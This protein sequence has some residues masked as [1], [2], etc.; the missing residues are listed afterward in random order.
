MSGRESDPKSTLPKPG[1][2]WGGGYA[3]KTDAFVERF[4]ESVSFDRRLAG[5]DIL[6]SQVHA[7]MLSRQKIIS[8]DDFHTIRSGLNEILEEIKRGEFEW[9]EELEDV[10]MNIEAELTSRIGEP[11]KRLHTG[12][13]RNDQVATDFRLYCAEAAAEIEQA[14][15]DLAKALNELAASDGAIVIPGYTHLQQGQPVTVATYLGAYRQMFERDARRFRGAQNSAMDECPLGS[16]AL[17]GSTLPLDRSFTAAKLGFERPS[18]N[19]M[20]AVSNRDFA[21]EFLLASSLLCVHLS[22]LAED[23]I[24]YATAEFG[25]IK[26]DDRVT[27]GSSLMPQKKNP[28][29][30]ELVR[31][32]SGSVIGNLVSLLTLLKGLPMTYNRDMQEDKRFVFAA[33]DTALDS[34]RAMALVIRSAHFQEEKI[35]AK[36]DSGMLATDLAEHLVE[37]GVPFRE[38]HEIVARFVHSTEDIASADASSLKE[39]HAALE[40]AASRLDFNEAI[41]RRH[42]PES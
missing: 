31:G 19:P 6:G 26:L 12:R 5:H 33:S 11:G 42:L 4:T 32:K 21:V 40:G 22:R 34:V 29:V 23:L 28:D 17:A 20:D 13:S 16:G 37:N 10:H 38:A 9:K 39:I 27:T 30:C 15:T 18:V 14:L 41:R 7:E 36:L 24:I 2:L 25:F 8:S 35:A 3:E 1:K